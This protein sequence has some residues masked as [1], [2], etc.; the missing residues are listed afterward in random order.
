MDRA[1]QLSDDKIRYKKNPY[2]LKKRVGKDSGKK[3]KKSG[4]IRGKKERNREK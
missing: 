1:G 3:R 4:K 2:T